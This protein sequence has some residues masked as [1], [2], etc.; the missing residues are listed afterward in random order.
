MAGAHRARIEWLRGDQ[1]FIDNRFSRAHHW[2]LDG[3]LSIAA[4][5]APGALPPPLSRIDAIDPE[6]AVVAALSA[7]HMLF[8]LGFAA[9]AGFCI[10]SYRDEPVGTLARNELG[11]LALSRIVLGPQITA[12]SAVKPMTAAD[13]EALHEAAHANCFIAHSLKSEIEI[14]TLPPVNH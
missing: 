11:K 9:K 4:S 13:V 8:F 1:P 7:C 5:A 12:V 14:R 2:H 10:D 3:G 6:E